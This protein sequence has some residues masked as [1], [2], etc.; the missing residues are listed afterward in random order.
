MTAYRSEAAKYA[1]RAF[2]ASGPLKCE[3][4]TVGTDSTMIVYANLVVLELN[5]KSGYLGHSAD[6]CSN[7]SLGA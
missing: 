7:Q 3:Q 6:D 1:A 4:H 2:A 5:Q